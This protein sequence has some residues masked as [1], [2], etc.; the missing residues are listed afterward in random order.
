[1]LI[2][3]I[4]TDLDAGTLFIKFKNDEYPIFLESQKDPKKLGRYSF[5]MSDPFLVLKS[6]G[7]CIE[8]SEINIKKTVDG[9]PFDILQKYLEKYHVNNISQIPF[10]GGAA[11]YLSYDLCHHIENLPVTVKDDVNIPDLFLGFYDGIIAIDHLEDKKYL[12]AHGIKKDADK[13][14]K[15]LEFK[16]NKKQKETKEEIIKKQEVLFKSNMDKKYYQDSINRIKDY[17]SSGDIYQINFTQRFECQLNKTPYTL[18]ERLRKKNPAPFAAYM[19]FGEGE[20]VCSSPERF[21]QVKDGI[22]ETRPIKGTIARGETPQEDMINKEILKNSEKDRSELLMI[23]DLERNDIGKISEAGSVEVPELFSIE[24]YA[25]VFQ[26]VATVRG[27]IKQNVTTVDI[28]KA[29]FPGG[30]ITGAPKIRAMEIIDELEQTARNIY[31]GSIGY[32]GFDGSIDLNIV[33]RTVLC[34]DEKAYFQVGGGIVWDSTSESEYKESIL[35]GKAL[36][37]ALSWRG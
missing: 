2:K 18:Y 36:K 15:N 9:N 3:E 22:I 19:N 20:I 14:I 31:T 23:V 34:K 5:I 37:E 35:K 26:Q 29:T 6:K 7:K 32:I 11:G 8:V 25:T 1:M 10:T 24:E 30:S 16:I 12:I 28:L 4:I 21:I 33:I 13:I 27:K 17:I